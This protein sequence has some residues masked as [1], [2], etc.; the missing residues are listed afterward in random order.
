MD[1]MI[2]FSWLKAFQSAEPHFGLERMKALLAYF[3]NPEEK[4]QVIHIGGTNGK[5]ST[6]AHLQQLLEAE[7]LKVGIFT[8][9]ALV[10][11]TEQFRINQD[12]MP[13]AILSSYLDR[14]KALLEKQ[15]SQPSLQGLTE[16][17]ILTALAFTYFYEEKVDLALFEVGMGG[18]L[19]STNVC[20]PILTAITSIGLDHTALLGDSLAEI[21]GHKAGIIK[22][23]VPI[24][25]GDLGPSARQVVERV[26]DKQEA[27]LLIMGQDFN[28]ELES[29]QSGEGFTYRSPQRQ[30]SFH[31]PLIGVHQAANASLAIAIFDKFLQL[32]GRKE[33][34]NQDL[35]AAFDQVSWPG[36]LE[37]LSE[38]PLIYIDGAHNPH[39]IEV[40]KKSLAQHFKDKE[41]KFLFTCIKTK[42]LDQMLDQLQEDFGRNICLTTF[43]DPRATDSLYLQELA[44]ERQLEWMPWQDYLDSYLSQKQDEK[45]LLVVTGS[46]YFLSQVRPYIL[47]QL[48][49][50]TN[51]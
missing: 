48:K 45:Q 51:G 29:S 18:D 32:Q 26:A 50:N 43:D 20:Q 8:S 9:P 16:F 31:T 21:A 34:S 17:E 41:I 28:Y 19:D 14:F 4:L 10:D 47:N 3:G 44:E 40:L 2:D 39:A 49:G 7:G 35:Q 12:Q 42:A 5:G 1:K 6:I 24:L 33:R 46:L 36:R 22:N 37:R 23:Q 25:I 38:N 15:A 13:L 27:P 11:F 30:G